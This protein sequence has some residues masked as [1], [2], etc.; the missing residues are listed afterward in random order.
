MDGS[1]Q[2]QTLYQGRLYGHILSIWTYSLA[3]RLD[4][5]ALCLWHPRPLPLSL[6]LSLGELTTSTLIFS[7]SL[8]MGSSPCQGWSAPSQYIGLVSQAQCSRESER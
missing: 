4:L 3:S 6:S 5:Q 8:R 7:V 2:S 1:F